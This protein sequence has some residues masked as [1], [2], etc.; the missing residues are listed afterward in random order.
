MY[1]RTLSKKVCIYILVLLSIFI[2]TVNFSHVTYVNGATTNSLEELQRQRDELQ[3]K[4]DQI[5]KDK[6]DAN[7]KLNS[8][9]SQKKGVENEIAVL[10]LEIN[11][12]QLVIDEK[13][14]EIAQKENEIAILEDQIASLKKT[15]NN[16]DIDINEKKVL[17]DKRLQNIYKVSLTKTA[18]TLFF[19]AVSA[20]DLLAKLKYQNLLR[21]KDEETLGSLK[22]DKDAYNTQKKDMEDKRLSVQTLTDSIIAQKVELENAKNILGIKKS[23]NQT[24]LA[25][26][27]N[28]VGYQQKNYD[29]LSN[30]QKAAEN[31]I[32]NV[33]AQIFAAIRQVPPSGYKILKG[34]YLGTMG[35]TGYCFGS[36]LHF[37]TS[38]NASASSN[39]C[40]YLPTG[41]FSFCGSSSPKIAWPLKSPFVWSRGFTSSHF[42]VDIVAVGSDKGVYASHDGW[43]FYGSESCSTWKNN[44]TAYALCLKNGPARYAIVCENK[45]SCSTGMKT[46]Y[47]HLK[48][49]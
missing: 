30:E 7:A 40:N 9:K 35:C 17:A 47:W 42:A 4:L 29:N 22:A 23:E 43:L 19:N 41:T 34:T 18:M 5:A 15:L 45:S 39:P 25:S 12:Q 6:A 46:G 27:S 37:F 14:T 8:A 49:L 10:T 48:N 36:H 24:K 32:A 3:K 2:F 28:T 21:N 1:A 44:K 13:E 38:Y 11:Q 26:L 33:Q 20:D 31:E 16:L